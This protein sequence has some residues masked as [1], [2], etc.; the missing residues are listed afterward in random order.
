MYCLLFVGYTSIHKKERA[1]IKE[2]SPRVVSI[3]VNARD[4]NVHLSLVKE[5]SLTADNVKVFIIVVLN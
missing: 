4:S 2:L 5:L 1:C 3:V